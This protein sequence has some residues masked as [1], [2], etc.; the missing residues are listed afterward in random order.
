MKKLI[1]ILLILLTTNAN[2]QA[3]KKL[4]DKVFKYSTV[5]VAGDIK[6]AYETQY[7]DY[8]IRT[9]PD[10]LYAVP[11]V[12]DETVYH[13]FDYRIGFGIRRMARFDYEIKQ[14]YIDGSENMVGLSAPTAA[15]KGFEYLVHFEKERERSEE[16]E[17]SRYF[18]RHTGKYH[19]VKLEQRKQGNVDFDYQSA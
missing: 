16:F 4:Y 19:I 3:L 15:V 10:D 8:F 6:E 9:N 13:P 11:D 17:N 7:P 18:I 5:Y 14:N 12:I 2:G 1:T